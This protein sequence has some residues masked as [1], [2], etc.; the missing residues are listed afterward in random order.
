M[1][2]FIYSKGAQGEN[3]VRCGGVSR[4]MACLPNKNIL[5]KHG[6]HCSIERFFFLNLPILYVYMRETRNGG[7]GLGGGSTPHHVGRREV[8]GQLWRS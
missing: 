6:K 8:K 7:W 3:S 4:Y 5:D 2:D 1:K